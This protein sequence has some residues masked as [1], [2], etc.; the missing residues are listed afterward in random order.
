VQRDWMDH[1]I[2][3]PLIEMRRNDIADI[4]RRFHVSRLDVFGS[5]ARG[6]DFDPARADVDL[7][8]TYQSTIPRPTLEEYFEF[9]EQLEALFGRSVDL[10]MAGAVRNPYVRADIERSRELVYEA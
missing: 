1:W 6:S 4:C 9:R 5:A 3:L 2:V 7:L 8:V 10:V